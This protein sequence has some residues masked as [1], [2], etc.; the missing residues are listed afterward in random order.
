MKLL[1][2]YGTLRR[3]HA[4]SARF[5]LDKVACTPGV[6]LMGHQLFDLGWYPGIRPGEGYVV[7]D[8]FEVP[9]E[10]WAALDQYE[11]VPTLYTRETVNIGGTEGVQVYI[12]HSDISSDKQIATGD[13]FNKAA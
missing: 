4:N 12:Y 11:G 5:G 8:V 2:A 6:K 9:E 10:Q 1:F 3:G 13:W 7:G